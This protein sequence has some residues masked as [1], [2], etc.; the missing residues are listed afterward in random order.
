MKKTNN[1]KPIQ[2]S[3]SPLWWRR[4][5]TILTLLLLLPLCISGLLARGTFTPL[6]NFSA[7]A[8]GNYPSGKLAKAADGTLYGTTTNGGPADLGTIYKISPA[9]VRTTVYNFAGNGDGGYHRCHSQ[10]STPS[11]KSHSQMSKLRHLA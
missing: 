1:L 5:L 11:M 6:I 2:A 7:G 9:G 8:N 4:K 3:L 10:S